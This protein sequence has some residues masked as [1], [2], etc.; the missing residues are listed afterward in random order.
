[1]MGLRW[2]STQAQ[3]EIRE[4]SDEQQMHLGCEE[5]SVPVTMNYRNKVSAKGRM[6][7]WTLW[8]WR[9]VRCVQRIEYQTVIC[10]V[11]GMYFSFPSLFHIQVLFDIHGW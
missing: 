7:E 9:V 8:N 3:L 2:G 11:V 10:S 4:V 1:M 5:G 6:E